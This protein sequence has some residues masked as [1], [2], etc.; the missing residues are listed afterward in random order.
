MHGRFSII[1]GHVPGL[2]PQVYA[3][4]LIIGVFWVQISLW[5]GLSFLLHLCLPLDHSL[6]TSALTTQCWFDGVSVKE[7][8][9][10]LHLTRVMFSAASFQ[11]SSP[12]G[13]TCAHAPMY[14]SFPRRTIVTSCLAFYTLPFIDCILI[15]L[16]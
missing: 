9:S 10:L 7:R 2:R 14:M 1:G 16:I 6:E 8:I 12:L 11:G 13:T 4:G 3:Y 5:M 15:R